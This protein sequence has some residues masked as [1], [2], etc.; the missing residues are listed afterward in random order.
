MATELILEGMHCDGCVRRVKKV[1]E[2]SGVVAT[3]VTVG[4]ATLEVAPESAPAVL[5]K[6]TAAGY[7]ARVA[8][9][10]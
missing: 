10:P 1:L 9:S 7:P 3:S 6:L 5:E 4:H 2:Q 8:P